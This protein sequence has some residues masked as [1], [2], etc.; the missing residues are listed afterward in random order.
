MKLNEKST[1]HGFTLVELLVV[2][3]IIALLISLLLPALNRARSAARTTQCLSNLKQMGAAYGLYMINSKGKLPAV[4]E[5][6][7]PDEP[8]FYDRLRAY[9][10]KDKDKWRKT[11]W[12]FDCPVYA[13]AEHTPGF[14]MSF[15]VHY[16]MWNKVRPSAEVLVVADARGWQGAGINISPPH[17]PLEPRRHGRTANYLFAD[18]HA[19]PIDFREYSSDGRKSMWKDYSGK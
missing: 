14:S 10:T 16:A 6:K 1:R 4:Y 11:G 7:E 8:F 19:E 15:A 18:W 12:L 9:L 5:P 17:E 3:G 2:I 13:D